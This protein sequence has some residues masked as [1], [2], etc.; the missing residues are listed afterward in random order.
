MNEKNKNENIFKRDWVNV[1]TCI[2]KFLYTH[3]LREM[4]K[5]FARGF[6]PLAWDIENKYYFSFFYNFRN[7]NTKSRV[8]CRCEAVKRNSR[9]SRV[10][11]GG[12]RRYSSDRGQTTAQQKQFRFLSPPCALWLSMSEMRARK[13]FI[14]K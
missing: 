8:W 9:R 10:K 12:L 6:Q 2:H 14:S 11:K 3:T 13:I 7:K 1:S 4:G 5:S